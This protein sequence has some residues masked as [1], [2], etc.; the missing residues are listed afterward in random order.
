MD[1]VNMD[2]PFQYTKDEKV[3]LHLYQLQDHMKGTWHDAIR[4][5]TNPEPT[6]SP[7]NSRG[8]QWRR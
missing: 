7:Y 8:W 4:A 1:P 2:D 6:I 5:A 3:D